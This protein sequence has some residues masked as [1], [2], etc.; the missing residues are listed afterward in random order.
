MVAGLD[1]LGPLQSQTVRT[2]DAPILVDDCIGNRRI[3]RVLFLCL[4]SGTIP[5]DC[6][7][8]SIG[9][10]AQNCAFNAGRLSKVFRHIEN[11]GSGGR[12]RTY[13]QL[14]NSQLLYR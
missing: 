1:L 13:D 12:D 8:G 6:T 7:G 4:L 2:A 3:Q 10:Q 11:F 9:F 5:D 14:I